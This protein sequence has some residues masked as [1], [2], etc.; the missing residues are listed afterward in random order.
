MQAV[1]SYSQTMGNA[2]AAHDLNVRAIEAMDLA[3]A[4]N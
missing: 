1:T 2:D 3:Y 4:S